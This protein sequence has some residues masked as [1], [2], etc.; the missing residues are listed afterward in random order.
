MLPRRDLLEGS[1]HPRELEAVIGAA[2]LALRTWE[3]VWSA[4]LE[5]EV[6][7]E[8]QQRLGDLSELSLS[9][10]GGYPGA[11]RRRLLLQRR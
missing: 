3:P 5:A 4:F 10:R 6:R 8:A 9:S 11:E 1:L 2:D 7:E